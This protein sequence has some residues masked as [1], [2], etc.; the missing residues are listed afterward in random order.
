M[1]RIVGALALI[2]LVSAFGGSAPWH[3]RGQVLRGDVTGDGKPESIVIEQRAPRCQFRL[4]AGSLTKRLRLTICREKPSEVLDGQDPHVAALVDI[5]RQPGV[6]IVIQNGHGAYMDFGDIWTYRDGVLRRYA[7][8]EPHLSWGASAGTGAHVV[9]CA[10]RRGVV[11]ISYRSFGP[12]GRVFRGWYRA[13][14]LRLKLIRT[15]TIRWNSEKAPP[16]SE[17]REPQPFPTCAKARA[18]RTP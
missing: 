8:R 4:A 13:Q 14:N 6:E 16:Y 7:G 11:L 5:D 12:R 15:K 2:A 10:P 3:Q 18:I 1:K 9:G 17:F